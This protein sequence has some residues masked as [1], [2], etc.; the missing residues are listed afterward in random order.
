MVNEKSLAN[1]RPF[2]KGENQQT[3][4]GTKPGPKNITALAREMLDQPCPK[5]PGLTYAQ[6]IAQVLMDRA[7]DGDQRFVDILLDR[8]EGRVPQVLTGEG[9]GPVV[10]KE[11]R[12]HGPD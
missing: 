1:L 12:I 3:R 5:R 4:K 7:V 6:A 2:K 11:V 9:G 10:I 8:L